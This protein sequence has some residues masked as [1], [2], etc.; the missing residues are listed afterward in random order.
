VTLLSSASSPA[1]AQAALTAP[2]TASEAQDVRARDGAPPAWR[3]SQSL[4]QQ[5]TGAGGPLE[6]LRALAT[7]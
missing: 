5:H 2:P 1:E 7:G 3:S 6:R 4:H